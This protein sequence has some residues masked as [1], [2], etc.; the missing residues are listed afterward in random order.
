MADSPLLTEEIRRAILARA[1]APAALVVERGHI[2]RFAEAIGDTNPLYH[3]EQAA[4]EGPHGGIVAPP[5]FL[6]A[7][8][9]GIP[10]PPELASLHR[11]LDGGSEWDYH[12]PVRIGDTITAVIR[13]TSVRERAIDVGPAVFLVGEIIYTNQSERTVARQRFTLIRYD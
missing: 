11:T 12:E 9:I 13:F 3:D 1:G 4:R 7:L 2:A 5:T 10:D 8:D 6:R